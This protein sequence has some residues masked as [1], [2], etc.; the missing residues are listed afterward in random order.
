MAGLARFC[1]WNDR[2]FL[3]PLF[4]PPALP[5][6]YRPHSQSRQY[7]WSFSLGPV[8]LRESGVM[9]LSWNYKDL[10]FSY[11]NFEIC[12]SIQIST[13]LWSRYSDSTT[14]TRPS[15]KAIAKLSSALSYHD[16]ILWTTFDKTITS[17]INGMRSGLRISLCL[18]KIFVENSL[19][20]K[21]HLQTAF[22]QFQ[23][24]NNQSH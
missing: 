13:N 24:S 7:I 20:L 3:Q 16:G 4:L 2:V 9:V 22:W 21:L 15:A 10:G 6:T 19:E 12:S 8:S 5:Y 14:R 18:S 11:I 23:W 1:S 17:S